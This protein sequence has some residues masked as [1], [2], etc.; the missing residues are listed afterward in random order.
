MLFLDGRHNCVV[1]KHRRTRFDSSKN[2]NSNALVRESA[3]GLNL[4]RNAARSRHPIRLS[5]DP[6]RDNR[7][8]VA[9][10]DGA[11]KAD[12]HQ[13]A[14][15][16]SVAFVLRPRHGG[17]LHE[18]EGPRTTPPAGTRTAGLTCRDAAML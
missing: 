3:R 9:P 7:Q 5:L 6:V 10:I 18:S 13:P 1:P 4:N 14:T 16:A 2:P 17:K 8:R 11:L 15:I 12:D